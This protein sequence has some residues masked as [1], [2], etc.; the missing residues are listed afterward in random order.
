MWGFLMRIT[1]A[2]QISPGKH[3]PGSQKK[4]KNFFGKMK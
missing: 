2:Q 3:R 1:F 4:V